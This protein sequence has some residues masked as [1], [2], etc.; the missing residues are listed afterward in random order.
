MNKKAITEQVKKAPYS[1]EYI[2]SY[3]LFSKTIFEYS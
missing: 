1:E 2:F 3:L